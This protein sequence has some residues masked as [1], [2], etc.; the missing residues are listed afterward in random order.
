MRVG[1]LGGTFDPIHD[2]HL[3]AAQAA[4]RCAGLDKVLLVPAG[5]PPHRGPADAT[6]EQRLA[7]C[8]LAARAN[9][10]LE[11]FDAEVRRSGRSYTVDTLRE[12][13]RERPGDDLYLILGWDAARELWS[14]REPEAVLDRARVVAIARPGLPPPSLEDLRAAGL[15]PTR[16]VL[17]QEPTPNIAATRIRERMA[18][19]AGLDGLVPA[20]VARYIQEH[21]LYR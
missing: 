18:E 16:V 4:I 5:T 12:L 13:E 1:I 7:M 3:A 2:G 11:V 17:C 20:A 14:W 8:E 9:P 21:R 15:D 10:K 6:A 19:G